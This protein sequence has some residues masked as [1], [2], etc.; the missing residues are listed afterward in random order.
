MSTPQP[1]V[2][3][4]ELS[5]AILTAITQA[6]TGLRYG[7]VT[8]IVQDG[9]V[10]QIDR[11]DRRSRVEDG[12]QGTGG[13]GCPCGLA[14]AGHTSRGRAGLPILRAKPQRAGDVSP[15][16]QRDVTDQDGVACHMDVD[17]TRWTYVQRSLSICLSML[18]ELSRRARQLV[19][20]NEFRSTEVSPGSTNVVR[21]VVNFFRVRRS[22]WW[23]T[24]GKPDVRTSHGMDMMGDPL[25]V[26]FRSAKERPF[27]ERKATMSVASGT[28]PTPYSPLT[29]HPCS[30]HSTAKRFAICSR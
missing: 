24:S 18:F 12:G 30:P 3:P 27:A 4:T 28:L 23:G 29:T 15:P 10:M 22:P 1:T 16:C 9:R 8:I 13:I 11:T 26:V 17:R 14:L 19:A 21:F 2:T 20:R 25:V 6:L 7:Q 5:T